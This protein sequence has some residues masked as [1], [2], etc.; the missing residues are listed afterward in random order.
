MPARFGLSYWWYGLLDTTQDLWVRSR[1][2]LIVESQIIHGLVFWKAF[3]A[4]IH[5]KKFCWR[6]ALRQSIRC[7]KRNSFDLHVSQYL[8]I[9]IIA[10]GRPNGG[11]KLLQRRP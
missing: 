9:N 3:R 4:V 10:P 7:R 2:P 1:L 11:T 5:S 8:Q 6:S